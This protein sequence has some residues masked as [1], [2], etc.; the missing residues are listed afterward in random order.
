MPKY[1]LD[2]SGKIK[3]LENLN[4]NNINQVAKVYAERG[5]ST[6]VVGDADSF[7]RNADVDLPSS[8][9]RISNSLSGV[10]NYFAVKNKLDGAD[11]YGLGRH[12]IRD[13]PSPAMGDDGFPIGGF[14][15]EHNSSFGANSGFKKYRNFNNYLTKGEIFATEIEMAGAGIDLNSLGFKDLTKY[16]L[17]IELLVESIVYMT[18]IESFLKVEEKFSKNIKEVNFGSYGPVNY[19]SI[20]KYFRKTLNYPF[21]S[22]TRDYDLEDRI[23]AYFLGMLLYV[24]TDP[25]LKITLNLLGNNKVTSLNS[26]ARYFIDNVLSFSNLEFKRLLMLVR[27]LNQKSEWFVNRLYVAKDT[28]I[29]RENVV[30]KFAAEFSYYYVK[31][32]IERIHVGL[33]ALNSQKKKS[34]NRSGRLKDSKKENGLYKLGYNGKELIGLD[35]PVDLETINDVKLKEKYKNRS[36]MSN[37]LLPQAFIMPQSFIRSSIINNKDNLSLFSGGIVDEY[38][39]SYF[40]ETEKH[41][42][43]LSNDVVRKLEE[44]YEKEIMPFY[45]Q[46]LR[47]NEIIGFHAFI[48]SIT[49]N[50]NPNYVSTKGFGRIDDVK[51]YTDTTRNVNITFTLAA[52][53][54]KDHDLMWYQIN[55]IVSMVYPQWSRGF[56]VDSKTDADN[57]KYGKEYPFTQVPTASPLIRIRLGDVIKSNYTKHAIEK[58]HG[59]GNKEFNIPKKG[60]VKKLYL[61]PGTYKYDDD[62]WRRIRKKRKNRS[63]MFKIYAQDIKDASITISSGNKEIKYI[64]TVDYDGGVLNYIYEEYERTESTV[65]FSKDNITPEQ[66]YAI[67]IE[68]EIVKENEILYIVKGNDIYVEYD[69]PDKFVEPYRKSFK[70]YTE[71]YTDRPDPKVLNNPITA[72]YESTFGKGLAGFITMLDVN[73]QDQLWETESDRVGSKAPKLVKMTINFAPIHD[74]P[75]G[76][77]A[78]GAMRAPVYNAGRIVNKLYGNVYD[79]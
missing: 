57:G 62:S 78:D 2:P 75:P 50:F 40:L 39:S 74:I 36:S 24:N 47:T 77:D 45:F 1:I 10:D 71:A 13:V 44:H 15:S 63:A 76:L 35:K 49:D 34:L 27:R 67:G 54:E 56:K 12:T 26:L 32:I 37:A 17:V 65:A 41:Q 79:N 72:A 66:Y 73:Y 23:S 4:N 29:T 64:N 58:I 51:H 19:T 42:E 21:G 3:D 11:R 31:F 20:T 6:Y 25:Q 68:S 53:S 38:I 69:D 59:S 61:K 8:I 18:A 60:K 52:M 55:K 43:R 7:G 48:D 9:L 5:G 28:D 16:T 70:T 22:R 46:D 14:K 33:K 30:E